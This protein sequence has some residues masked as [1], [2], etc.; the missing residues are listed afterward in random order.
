MRRETAF[1]EGGGEGLRAGPGWEL[2]AA[3]EGGALDLGPGQRAQG[4]VRCRVEPVAA[5]EPVLDRGGVG[6]VVLGR[7]VG[8]LVQ[9]DPGAA[10]VQPAPGEACPDAGEQPDQGV[11]GVQVGLQ[12]EVAHAEERPELRTRLA[13]RGGGERRPRGPAGGAASGPAGG[14][15]LGDPAGVEHPHRLQAGSLRRVRPGRH[16]HRMIHQ[17]T[18]RQPRQARPKRQPRL[19]SRLFQSGPDLC[20]DAPASSLR[21]FV[22]A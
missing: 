5:V 8:Q 1:G 21:T 10:V 14:L 16:D 12:R 6:T 3:Q 19:E 22:R 18:L 15:V 7:E 11:G 9:D 20:H 2:V 13:Q 17:V 4:M